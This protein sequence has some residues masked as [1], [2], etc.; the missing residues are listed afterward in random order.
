MRITACEASIA[1]NQWEHFYLLI[2]DQMDVFIIDVFARTGRDPSLIR[3][4]SFRLI[5]PRRPHRDLIIKYPD[6]SAPLERDDLSV[7]VHRDA[8][9]PS[10]SQLQPPLL[11][12]ESL[13]K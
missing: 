9:F 2:R 11:P 1:S 7:V 3:S 8:Y 6:Q 4:P 13:T 5:A 12:D 10:C